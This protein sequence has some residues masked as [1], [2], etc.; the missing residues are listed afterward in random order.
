MKPGTRIVLVALVAGTLGA[1]ASLAT[2]GPGPL[3]RTSALT[4]LPAYY[5][6]QARAQAEAEV[7]CF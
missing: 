3:L 4:A 1:M 7:R 5:A 6:E 2:S